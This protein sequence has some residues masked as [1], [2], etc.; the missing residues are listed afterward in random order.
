METERKN[1]SGGGVLFLGKREKSKVSITTV[2]DCAFDRTSDN[3]RAGPKRVLLLETEGPGFDL[4]QQKMLG[5]DRWE[6]H[7]RKL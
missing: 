4:Q 7:G 2:G 1:V 3:S 6:F 5:L